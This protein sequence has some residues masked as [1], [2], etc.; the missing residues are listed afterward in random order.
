V[1]VLVVG[2]EGIEQREQSAVGVL[3]DLG[4]SLRV[5]TLWDRLDDDELGENPPATVLIEA[6]DE[7]DA[8][9]AA[10]VRIRAAKSLAEVPVLIGITVSALSR[11]DVGDGYDDFTLMPYVP[12]ELY[13]RIRRVD[14]SR[15]DFAQQERV[16][17]GPLCIDLAAHEVTVDGRS[18]QLTHQEFALLS[19]LCQNRGR[20]FSRRQ[21]L[22]RVWGVDYYGS[23]RTVDIHVRRLRMKLGNSINNLETVR[24]VGYKMKEP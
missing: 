14:W 24:G 18:R 21:L 5:A 12:A 10:L 23:S 7:A 9:R 2:R 22:E 16:K 13:M 19:F 4:C 1:W 3:Q 15:S 11:L 17:M 6:G 20:V 8:A